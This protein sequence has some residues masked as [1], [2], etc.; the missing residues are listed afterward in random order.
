MQ[1]RRLSAWCGAV[2]VAALG[3]GSVQACTSFLLK[4]ND[5]GSVYGRTMEFGLPLQSA[6]TLIQRG[7]KL[8]GVGLT[9]NLEVASVGKRSMPLLA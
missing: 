9:A 6:A 5:G 7:A 2:L 8:Q 3:P 4:G 1:R